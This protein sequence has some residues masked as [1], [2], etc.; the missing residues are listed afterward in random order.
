MRI[1]VSGKSDLVFLFG[2][3]FTSSK[4]N[5][6]GFCKERKEMRKISCGKGYLDREDNNLG[7]SWGKTASDSTSLCSHGSTSDS[8]Q[9]GRGGKREGWV[10]GIM[11]FINLQ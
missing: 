10:R 2:S 11:H 6:S 5:T 3:H 8:L 4:I 1:R 7:P 9:E